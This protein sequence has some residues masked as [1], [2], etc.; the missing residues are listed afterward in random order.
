MVM[1]LKKPA[2]AAR[3]RALP[4]LMTCGEC[5]GPAAQRAS[6]CVPFANLEMPRLAR[7]LLERGWALSG[8]SVPGGDTAAFCVCVCP[9]CAKEVYGTS[10]MIAATAV[11][12]KTPVIE[13][14]G[15]RTTVGAGTCNKCGN[16]RTPP[17][18]HENTPADVPASL[19]G[20]LVR[21]STGYDSPVLPDGDYYEFELC[22]PCVAAYIATLSTPP[23]RIP[24]I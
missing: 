11:V 6:I 18:A 2:R 8:A 21:F 7:Y 19:Y 23:A 1:K 14:V 9:A 10:L 5:T 12:A 3:G 22:E 20:A 16:S 24:Y 17:A 4:L 13:H 15:P